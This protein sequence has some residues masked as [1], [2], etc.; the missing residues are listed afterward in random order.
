[1]VRP[2]FEAVLRSS[3]ADRLMRLLERPPVAG[4]QRL[5]ILTYHQV[6][7][8]A[9]FAAQVEHLASHYHVLAIAEVLDLISA[10]RPLPPR[11]LLITF[12]DAYRNVATIAWP[13]LRAHNVP[14]TLFV[15]TGFPDRPDRVPWWDQLEYALK[16]TARREPLDSAAGRLRL[17]T[18]GQRADSL[19]RLKRRLWRL[20]LNEVPLVTAAVCEALGVQPPANAILGWDELRRLAAEGLALGAHTRNHPN[21]ARLTPAEARAEIAGSLAD[22]AREI[23]PTLPIFAYPGGRYNAET[24]EVLRDL[25]VKLAFT[26]RR[27]TNDMSR[28][29]EW[30]QQR[31]NNIGPDATL[32]VLRVRLLQASSVLDQFRPLEAQAPFTG[33]AAS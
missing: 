26:S 32:A 20:P 11:A 6:V 7:D 22:L 3:L 24:V 31:R 2:I 16:H 8:A 29:D 19:R 1:M 10:G 14:A 13:V 9:G 18:P 21:L 33:E 17:A 4:S 15:P 25:G 27:G 30:L 28:P 5:Q 23:G 12:D